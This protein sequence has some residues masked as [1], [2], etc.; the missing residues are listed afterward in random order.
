MHEYI[1][2]LLT[3]QAKVQVFFLQEL[4]FPTGRKSFSMVGE[5]SP[6]SNED[7]LVIVGPNSS[8]FIPREN[9]ALILEATVAGADV[10]IP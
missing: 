7:G 2:E 3:R 10:F 5:L 4:T 9:V 6:L 8:C 1:Q